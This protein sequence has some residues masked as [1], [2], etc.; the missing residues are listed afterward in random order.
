[1]RSNK[2]GHASKI[3]LGVRGSWSEET[4]KKTNSNV[5]AMSRDLKGKEG[6]GHWFY[7]CGCLALPLLSLDSLSRTSLNVKSLLELEQS[8]LI[9][10]LKPCSYP[11]L[12]KKW[13]L[14]NWVRLLEF[15]SMIILTR[16]DWGKFLSRM[17]TRW[18]IQ[19][20]GDLCL[21]A[22]YKVCNHQSDT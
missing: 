5:E 21:S 15:R 14:Q 17:P 9:V 6:F 3:V 2:Q 13:K 12:I 16:P 4:R 18:R 11:Y 10:H 7:F 1:M 20:L 19:I 8:L 22:L